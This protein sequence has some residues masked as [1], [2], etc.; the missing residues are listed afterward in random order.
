MSWSLVG[1]ADEDQFTLSADGVLAFKTA[2]DFEAPD[3]ADT[4]GDYEIEVRVTD[5][6]NATDAALTIRLTDVS[7]TAT[8]QPAI[9]GT[10]PQVGQTFD[11]GEGHD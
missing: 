1:G 11:R 2:K 4:D 7:A 8:G 6:Y 10:V 5:G 9:S 3:D